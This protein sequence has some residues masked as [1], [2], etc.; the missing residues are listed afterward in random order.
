MAGSPTEGTTLNRTRRIAAS[1]ATVI[2]LGG[3][4]ACG[5]GGSD[6]GDDITLRV[7]LFGKF[8]YAEAYKKFEA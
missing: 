8:G 5:E 7:N 6:D 4:A 1:L 3:L 2:A